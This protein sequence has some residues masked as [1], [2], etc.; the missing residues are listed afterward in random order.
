MNTREQ[1]QKIY[2]ELNK[3]LDDKNIKRLCRDIVKMIRE[4]EKSNDKTRIN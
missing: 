1:S 2:E 4:K 3:N